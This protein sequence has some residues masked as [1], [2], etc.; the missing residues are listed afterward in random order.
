[1]KHPPLYFLYEI[2]LKRIF[3]EKNDKIK[4]ESVETL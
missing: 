4:R 3:F 1:M 2:F